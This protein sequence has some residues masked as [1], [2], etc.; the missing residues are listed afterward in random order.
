MT[1]KV[2]ISSDLNVV[3]KY[4]KKLNNVDGSDIMSPR[5]PQSK[6]YL[7]ILS[8]S[9]FIE[10]SN[11]SDIIERIIKIFYIFD[12][13]ILA[14]QPHIIKAFLKFSIAVV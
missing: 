10:D 7:K 5:L 1:K 2:A 9:Y 6:S 4:M 11:L 13:I 3:E 8:I 14:S 12:D